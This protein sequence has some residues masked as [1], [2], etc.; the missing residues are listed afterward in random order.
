MLF[1]CPVDLIFYCKLSSEYLE[2]L[3]S[4]AAAFPSKLIADDLS[5]SSYVSELRTFVSRWN[6]LILSSVYS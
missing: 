2:S 5:N 1:N 4:I 6:G 3:V